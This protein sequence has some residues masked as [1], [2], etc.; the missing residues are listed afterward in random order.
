MIKTC[1]ICG[2]EFQTFGSRKYCS[3][4]CASIGYK[5]NRK[6]QYKN[7]AYS[8]TCATC[9]KQFE[10]IYPQHRFCS[11]KCRLKNN[12]QKINDKKSCLHCKKKFKPSFKGEKFCSDKCRLDYFAHLNRGADF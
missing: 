1:A 3:D 11:L 8:K 10:T 5:A 4:A 2:K 7:T 12:P 9:G 6:K